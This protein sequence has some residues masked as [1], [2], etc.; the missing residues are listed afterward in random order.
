MQ[1]DTAPSSGKNYLLNT[2]SSSRTRDLLVIE[3]VFQYPFLSFP[4]YT[5]L[6]L[7]ATSPPSSNN[8]GNSSSTSNGVVSDKIPNNN[9][10]AVPPILTEDE[11][12]EFWSLMKDPTVSELKLNRVI[13]KM[14]QQDELS[15]G[16]SG[17]GG[18]LSMNSEFSPRGVV[19]NMGKVFGV[20]GH[21][22]QDVDFTI[23]SLGGEHKTA[24]CFKLPLF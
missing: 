19:A 23:T 20:G 12:K 21:A 10:Q 17:G 4:G 5:S 13:R 8:S 2:C 22:E 24:F 6:N 7:I 3:K 14:Q 1:T 11:D 18:A 15:L 9:S 16:S